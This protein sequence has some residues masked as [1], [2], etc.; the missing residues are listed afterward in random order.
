MAAEEALKAQGLW[1][2]VNNCPIDI[3]VGNPN[4][5][6]AAVAAQ[7]AGEPLAPSMGGAAPAS[8]ANARQVGGTHYK[9]STGVQHWDL[10]HLL[11]MDY[12][13][14]QVTRYLSRGH[15]KNGA[16]D[17]AKAVHYIDKRSELGIEY[18]YRETYRGPDGKDHLTHVLL[19]DFCFRQDMSLLA[20]RAFHQLLHG[21]VAD[22]RAC[23]EALA[24]E[25]TFV[26][27]DDNQGDPR[28]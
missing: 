20:V 14:A 26:G 18:V 27:G 15:R 21:N 22:A 8:S 2:Y 11:D 9:N 28:P 16:E 25:Q 12:F 6:A 24:T 13:T 19:W 1:D 4:Y 7:L 5:G 23:A 10:V 3:E 17:F